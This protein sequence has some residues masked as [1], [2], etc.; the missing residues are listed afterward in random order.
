MATVTNRFTDPKNSF[1]TIVFK[2]SALINFGISPPDL[3]DLV[4]ECI[5]SENFDGNF[6]NINI[7]A[8]RDSLELFG[9]GL[10]KRQFEEQTGDTLNKTVDLIASATHRPGSWMTNLGKI[11]DDYDIPFFNP[12]LKAAFEKNDFEGFLISPISRVIGRFS[13]DADALPT[14]DERN[15]SRTIQPFVRANRAKHLSCAPD[16]LK[17]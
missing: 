2:V 15:Q 16:F 10:E 3:V 17:I 13:S 7:G 8:I 14:A 12:D 9:Y 6:A 11:A 4:N 1:T 5:T